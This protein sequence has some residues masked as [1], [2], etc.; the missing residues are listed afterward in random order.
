MNT[1]TPVLIPLTAQRKLL[2]D[3]L[4]SV[5]L[6]LAQ[7]AD[8]IMAGFDPCERSEPSTFALSAYGAVHDL[9]QADGVLS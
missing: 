1:Q 4:R 5:S 6:D 2:V 3:T 7:M 9:M 8:D